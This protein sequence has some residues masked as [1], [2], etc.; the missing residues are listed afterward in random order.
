MYTQ[1]ICVELV[2]QWTWK[3]RVSVHCAAALERQL[4]VISQHSVLVQLPCQKTSSIFLLNGI[5]REFPV[6]LNSL[7]K[8]TG[9]KFNGDDKT[10]LEKWDKWAPANEKSATAVG[11]ITHFFHRKMWWITVCTLGEVLAKAATGQFSHARWS[12]LHPQCKEK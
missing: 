2:S 12:C 11:D 1:E 5:Y 8:K 6:K 9:E 7:K 3:K 4:A 10:F